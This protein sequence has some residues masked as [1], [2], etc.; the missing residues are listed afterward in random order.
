MNIQYENLDL[1]PELYKLIVKLSKDIEVLKSYKPN[2]TKATEVYNFLDI[3]KTTLY[4]LI[5]K[6][7]LKENIHYSKRNGKI[8]FIEDAIVK[9]KETFV[10]HAKSNKTI[11]K[12]VDN[13][14]SKI[15][16]AA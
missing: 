3:S 5:N 4:D 8:I 15:K 10:K 9:Y 11:T 7:S 14:L 6:G 13:M 12:R 1:I 2:L 16:Q